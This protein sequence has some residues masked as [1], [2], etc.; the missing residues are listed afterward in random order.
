MLAIGFSYILLLTF[1][2]FPEGRGNLVFHLRPSSELVLCWHTSSCAYPKWAM[3]LNVDRHLIFTFSLS[4]VQ[5]SWFSLTEESDA[6][7]LYKPLAG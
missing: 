5:F 4:I 2:T 1:F 7:R 6:S 3:K